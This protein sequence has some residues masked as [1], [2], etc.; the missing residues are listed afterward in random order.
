MSS[1][2]VNGDNSGGRVKVHDA[3]Q[4]DS[5]RLLLA[6]GFS[7]GAK[8]VGVVRVKDFKEMHLDRMQA[9]AIVASVANIDWPSATTI[10]ADGWRIHRYGS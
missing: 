4:A 2:P 10:P 7:A 6:S 9:G 5:G 8:P 3:V 1:R